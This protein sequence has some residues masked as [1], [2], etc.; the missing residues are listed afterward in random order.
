M[1]ALLVVNW[2]LAQPDGYLHVVFLDMDE[3]EATLVTTPNGRQILI[4]GG[5]S[6]DKLN[7]Q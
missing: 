7:E 4:N 5:R 2:S 1:I 3:G 6:P